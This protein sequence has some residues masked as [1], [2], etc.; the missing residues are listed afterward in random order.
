[1]TFLYSL[2]ACIYLYLMKI[3]KSLFNIRLLFPNETFPLRKLLSANVLTVE[4]VRPDLTDLSSYTLE[5]LVSQ[6]S[7]V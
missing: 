7:V 3:C 2:N 1:M 6:D 5:T 4:P